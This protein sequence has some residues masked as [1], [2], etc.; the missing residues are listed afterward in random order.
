M[1]DPFTVGVSSRFL[2]SPFHLGTAIALENPAANLCASEPLARV[3][4]SKSVSLSQALLPQRNR[5][6]LDADLQVGM[7]ISKSYA[8]QV[9]VR[10]HSPQPE[11]LVEL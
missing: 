9:K 5:S 11:S 2:F 10:S 6:E 4:C 7:D 8:Q 1:R 3:A